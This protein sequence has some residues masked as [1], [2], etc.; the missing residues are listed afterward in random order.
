MIAHDS[1]GVL[2]FHVG[3]PCVLLS[4]F[5]FQVDNFSEYKWIVI[6]LGMCIDI[7]EIWFGTAT[8]E[9]SQFLTRP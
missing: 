6:K 8:G 4:V 7:V 2:W 9:F 5:L 3:R 1:S